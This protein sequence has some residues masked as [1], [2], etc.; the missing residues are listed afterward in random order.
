[1]K[2]ISHRHALVPDFENRPGFIVSSVFAE[3]PGLGA[4]GMNVPTSWRDGTAPDSTKKLRALARGASFLC[5]ML[6]CVEAFGLEI[7]NYLSPRNSERPQRKAT[8]YIVLHTTE[9]QAAGSLKKLHAN[10]E[11]HYFVDPSGKIYRIIQEDRLAL[12]AGR[13]VWEGRHNI[14]NYSIGIEVCG[15]YNSDI[16]SAQARSIKALLDSIQSRFGIPDNRVLTHSMVAYGTPNRWHKQPHRGRKRC[17]MLFARDSVRSRIGLEKKAAFDPDV[18]A[19]RVV[20]GDPYLAQVLYGKSTEQD[21]AVMR[22]TASDADIISRKRSAWD[23]AGDQ[24]K[25]KDV[26]YHFPDG[27]VRRGN[28]IRDW[29][30][31][32]AGTK[33]VMS[34]LRYDDESESILEIGVDGSCASEVAGDAYNHGTT[35]YFMP[36]GRMKKGNELSGREFQLLPEK[37]KVL[38]GYTFGGTIT[39]KRSAYQICGKAW[40]FPSTYYRLPD[41]SLVPGSKLDQGQIP[42]NSVVFFRN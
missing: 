25:S 7:Q 38:V 17:G 34:E 36:D 28:E 1:M 15:Y 12:H 33:V 2:N 35:F 8:C 14:D 27:K 11:A 26:A 29:T 3:D 37:T 39:G 16:T 5:V 23:I 21:Q 6:C 4:R 9:G 32:P 24:Y 10:G 20:V 30:K 13:S 31:I 40:N 18:K 42:A 41:G 22:F 19:G